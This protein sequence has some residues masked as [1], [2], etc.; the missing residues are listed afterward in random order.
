MHIV[1]EGSLRPKL[2]KLI[3]DLK[4]VNSVFLLG[5]QTKIEKYYMQSKI[6]AFSSRYEGFP[7]ALLEAMYFGLPCVSTDCPTGPAEIINNNTNG[8]L[9]PTDNSKLLAQKLRLLI[10]DEELRTV[11]GNNAKIAV[12]PYH[13]ST[14]I[15]RWNNIINHLLEQKTNRYIS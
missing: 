15:N 13:I 3:A 10:K 6:F 9:V 7:N 2:E 8:Y 14:I 11:I 1:G 5:K 12:Q 4:L